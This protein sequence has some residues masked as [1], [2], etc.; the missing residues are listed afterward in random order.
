MIIVELMGGLGNQMFQ[1]AAG[2]H[3]ALLNQTELALDIYYLLDRGPR[4][5][6]HFVYRNFDLDIFGIETPAIPP[7]ISL[8]YGRCAPLGRQILNRF[9]SP[10]PYRYT[11]E[12]H[13]HFDPAL[14]RKRGPLYLSGYWQSPRYFEAIGAVIR[15]D[16]RF[17]DPLPGA[18]RLL[19]AQIQETNSVCL[20]V[21]R[22]DFVTN[23]VHGTFGNDYYR[24][25]EALLLKKVENPHFFVFS[26]DLD[27][28]RTH[29]ALRS[30][31]TL[32][33]HRHAG[34]KFRHYLF[35]MSCCRH[36]IIPNST[37]AWWA[38]WLSRHEE[39]VVIGPGK[40]F[41]RPLFARN[42]DSLFP[43][44]WIRM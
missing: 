33:D 2:R 7:E 8:K 38:A 9:R 14:L 20:N 6:K 19:L 31:V 15:D 13:F 32:V 36:F 25:A 24:K 18:S 16:F 39:K 17:S 44:G 12:R 11:A 43:E 28:C 41:S 40:W 22:A 35:L 30:P 29:L 23:P 5:D 42:T 1:Y 21:R 26:D 37:F 34:S 27:W 10:G 3:L 4:L